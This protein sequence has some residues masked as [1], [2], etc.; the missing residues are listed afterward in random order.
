MNIQQAIVLGM[1]LGLTFGVCFLLLMILQAI[2][3]N[4]ED[5]K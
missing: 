3:W 1:N 5:R 4:K 2:R